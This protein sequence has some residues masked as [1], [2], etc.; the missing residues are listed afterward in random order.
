[1]V[2]IKLQV[3]HSAGQTEVLGV[4]LV[5][6]SA[7]RCVCYCTSTQ[8]QQQQRYYEPGIAMGAETAEEGHVSFQA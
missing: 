6:A 4:A 2:L 7:T 8:Q 5:E 1:M 3:L